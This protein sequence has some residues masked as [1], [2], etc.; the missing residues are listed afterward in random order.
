MVDNKEFEWLPNV[1]PS[2]LDK[3]N[4]EKQLDNTEISS[5]TEENR[6]RNT[7][8]TMKT[9]LNVWT[10]WCNSINE[11]RPMQDT[12]PEELN[13][14]LAHFFIKVRKVNGEFELRT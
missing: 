10:H 7:T 9:Y 14:L 8:K 5:F 12:P 6:N 4:L 1:D 13:S 11:R 3:S 2:L